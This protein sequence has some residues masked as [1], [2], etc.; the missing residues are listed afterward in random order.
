MNNFLRGLLFGVGIGL[1]IAPMKG[2]EMRHL[3]SE[4]ANE[5]RGYLPENEQLNQ[6]RQQVSDRLSQTAGSLKGYAQQ[7]ATTVR[8][9]T[10]NLSDI[11]QNAASSVKSTGED[12]SKLTK[13]TT[14]NT[15][16]SPTT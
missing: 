5:L 2:E 14:S 16:N 12:V 9:A 3:I 6:Y 15:P 7:A 4:R 13:D 8:Q 11:S 10:N 1:L